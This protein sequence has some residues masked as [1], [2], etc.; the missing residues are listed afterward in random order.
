MDRVTLTSLA[1]T[2]KTHQ[3]GLEQFIQYGI[4]VPPV[5]CEKCGSKLSRHEDKRLS[6]GFSFRCVKGS[7]HKS[8]SI[9]YRSWLQHVRIGLEIMFKLM[10]MWCYQFTSKQICHELN[11]FKLTVS[12]KFQSFREVC[13]IEF[14]KHE[15]IGGQGMVVQIDE[16]L[17]YKRKYDRGRFP[18]Q[19]WVFGGIDEQGKIFLEVVQQRNAQTLTEVLLRRV[20]PRSIIYSDE[21]RGYTNIP[22]HFEHYQVNHSQN[23][24]NPVDGTNTQR[25]E[26]TWSV[27]KRVL[28]M[29]GTR[30]CDD[31]DGYLSEF[32]FRSQNKDFPFYAF[33]ALVKKHYNP[34]SHNTQL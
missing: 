16:T 26:G 6:D 19:V 1:T 28:R 7:C 14:A 30:K 34:I 9:R 29:K 22:D 31:I 8:Y 12:E 10:Y 2:V 11:L 32:I 5:V 21:W 20:A 3:E 18:A 17:I 33:S 13:K 4:I 27:L 15:V 25:I 24:V 23:F